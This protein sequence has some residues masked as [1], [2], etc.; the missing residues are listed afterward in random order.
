MG[1]RE[2]LEP[3]ARRETKTGTA[4]SGETRWA[5]ET[6]VRGFAAAAAAASLR[7]RAPR[8]VE[9]ELESVGK[10]AGEEDK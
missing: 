8:V 10:E 4:L 2:G 3:R 6:K 9:S 7:G 1:R 5:R